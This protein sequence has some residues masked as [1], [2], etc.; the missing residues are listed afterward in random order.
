MVSGLVNLRIMESKWLLLVWAPS[1]A[2]KERITART[3][4]Q[5]S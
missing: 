2:E 4:S 3:R 5:G 1:K